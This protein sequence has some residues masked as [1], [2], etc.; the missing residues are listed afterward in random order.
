MPMRKYLGWTSGVAV[1]LIGIVSL[2]GS[3]GA[4]QDPSPSFGQLVDEV[5]KLER[6]VNYVE[7]SVGAVR[8][9]KD[10][11]LLHSTLGCGGG[12]TSVSAADLKARIA[13]CERRLTKLHYENIAYLQQLG[14]VPKGKGGLDQ[15]LPDQ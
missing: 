2:S 7:G 9:H 11:F 6:A 8:D 4:E 3:V 10:Q 12:A 5:R 15:P 13:D 14:R 1:T